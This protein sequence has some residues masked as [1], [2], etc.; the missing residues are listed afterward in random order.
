MLF[1]TETLRLIVALDLRVPEG[2]NERDLAQELLERTCDKLGPLGVTIKI[3]TIAR[4][5]GST[6]IELLQDNGLACF[7][8]L[9]LVDIGNTLRNE[10]SWIQRYAPFMLTV[11]ERVKPAVFTELMELLPDTLV[12]PVGPLTDFDD[13]DFEHFGNPNEQTRN[14]A[15]DAFFKRAWR[16]KA[17]GVVCAPTDIKLTAPGFRESVTFVTPAVQPAWLVNDNTPNALTPAMAI[18]AGAGALVVGRGIT[19]QEDIRAAAEKTLEEMARA[20]QALS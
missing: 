2:E 9:K 16:L 14:S 5:L 3:N 18:Q 8:D 20:R 10:V 13:K 11:Y 1:E 7:L 12:L 6:A 19:A 15:V 4:I 17:Q